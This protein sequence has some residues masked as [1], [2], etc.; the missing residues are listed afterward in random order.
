MKTC[1]RGRH[2]GSKPGSHKAGV[3]QSRGQRKAG[4]RKAGVRKSRGHPLATPVNGDERTTAAVP[5]IRSFQSL[6]SPAAELTAH[7]VLEQWLRCCAPVTH[8]DQGVRTL[9]RVA[10]GC[11]WQPQKTLCSPP[12]PIHAADRIGRTGLW[13]RTGAI[14]PLVAHGTGAT[15]S[16][17]P[18]RDRRWRAIRS[19]GCANPG[20]TL[21]PPSH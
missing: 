6:Y 9:R 2:R 14:Q 3:T 13:L 1:S 12:R 18:G 21:P 17:V 4:V 16:L 20:T 15:N 11:R 7:L 8:Q 10:P 19:H 5:R